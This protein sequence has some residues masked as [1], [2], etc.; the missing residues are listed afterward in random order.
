MG[1]VPSGPAARRRRIDPLDTDLLEALEE[2]DQRLYA[3]VSKATRYRGIL[4]D[5]ANRLRMADD[6]Q[7]VRST[8]A[9]WDTI[10][11]EIQRLAADL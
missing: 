8:L 1:R 11:R 5:Q 2:R 7:L 3:I 9:R 6:P 10:L 4:T